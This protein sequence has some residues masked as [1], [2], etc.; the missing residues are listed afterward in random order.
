[1]EKLSQFSFPP[2]RVE[3]YYTGTERLFSRTYLD[4][5]LIYEDHTFRPSPLYGVDSEDAMISLLDFLMMEEKSVEKDY[6]IQR[7]CPALD[8]FA[9]E[10]GEA[11]KIREMISDYMLLRDY[12]ETVEENEMTPEQCLEINKYIEQF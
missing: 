4:D 2:L 8:Q 9:W 5:R 1:M 11:E 3:L 6:F 10:S 7:N 12:P